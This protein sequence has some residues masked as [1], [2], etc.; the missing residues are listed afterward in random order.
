[1]TRNVKIKKKSGFACNYQKKQVNLCHKL[2]H[3]NYVIEQS[4]FNR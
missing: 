1:M 3:N 2:N 4:Y